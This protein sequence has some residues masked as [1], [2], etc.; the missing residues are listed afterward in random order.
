MDKDLEFLYDCSNEQLV[1]LA[2]MLRYDNDGKPLLG[3]TL[4]TRRDYS[5]N[6]PHSMKEAI[7]DI[8]A[9]L[10]KYGDLLAKYSGGLFSGKCGSYRKLLECICSQ[11]SVN[12]NDFNSI[13]EL[14][15]L[16]AK[17][18]IRVS[19]DSL[20]DED[21]KQLQEKRFRRGDF[22]TFLAGFLSG[23]VLLLDDLI[24]PSYRIT[25]PCLL[26]IAYY[27]SQIKQSMETES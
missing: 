2:D 6:Y 11:C 16:L 17:K 23:N 14:E 5:L 20:T 19:P 9:E 25:L 4:S 13:E 22:N 26:T 3:Q 18:V 8:V 10:L 24:K 7:P 12:Y 21:L 1:K 27:R 15:D